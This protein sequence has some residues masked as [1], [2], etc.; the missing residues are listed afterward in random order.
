M[1][2]VLSFYCILIPFLAMD[3][4]EQVGAVHALL[5]VAPQTVTGVYFL[6]YFTG[7]EEPQT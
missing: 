6:W 3:T 1:P 5:I 4:P 7:T 2:T